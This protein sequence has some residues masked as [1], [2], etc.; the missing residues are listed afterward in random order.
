MG[1]GAGSAT[2]SQLK[3]CF[4]T[5]PVPGHD[6]TE[7]PSSPDDPSATPNGAGVTSTS[8]GPDGLTGIR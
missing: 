8:G 3:Y 6:V 4:F 2:P 5:S 1:S 7:N